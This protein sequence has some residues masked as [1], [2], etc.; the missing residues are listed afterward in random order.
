[1]KRYVETGLTTTP[2]HGRGQRMSKRNERYI[3]S[4]EE[5]EE[6]VL[7]DVMNSKTLKFL[8]IP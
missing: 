8:W 4:E 6:R 5:E 7:K 1:M 3:E 2:N